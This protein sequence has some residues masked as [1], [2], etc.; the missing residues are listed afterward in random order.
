MASRNFPDFSV[1]ESVQGAPQSVSETS[2]LPPSSYIIQSRNGFMN[3]RELF[4]HS[5]YS[6]EYPEP[7][8]YADAPSK[9][10]AAP[11]SKGGQKV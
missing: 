8:V 7:A 11:G 10:P 9:S 2:P 5:S 6:P 3:A 1:W 4:S